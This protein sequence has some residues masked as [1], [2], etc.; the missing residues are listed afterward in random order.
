MDVTALSHGELEMYLRRSYKVTS[1]QNLL[2]HQLSQYFNLEG[3]STVNTGNT[4]REMLLLINGQTTAVT[5]FCLILRL[6]CQL[7]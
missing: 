3:Y 2:H 7:H 4:L 6:N 1:L 5:E